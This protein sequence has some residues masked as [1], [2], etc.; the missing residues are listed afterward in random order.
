MKI[1]TIIFI[2]FSTLAMVSCEREKIIELSSATIEIENYDG[3]VI[4]RE[5][6]EKV[7]LNVVAEAPAG[8]HKIEVLVAG[9]VVATEQPENSFTYN[10]EYIY[11]VSATAT[12]G[13]EVTIVFKLE[14]KQG[15][16]VATPVVTIKVAQPFEISDFSI[17]GNA[18]KKISGRINKDITLTND[19][20]WLIDGIVSVDEGANLTIEAGTTV[21]FRTFNNDKYSQLVIMRGGKV[22]ASGSRDKPI[23]FT[24][25][26]VL[27]GTA[28]VSDWGGVYLNGSAP[29]NAANTVLL[30]GF[31]YGGTNVA[32]NSGTLRFVRIEY[33]GKGGLHSLQLNG[34]GSRTTIEYV[35]SFNS[36]NNAFRL[37][38][39]RV[40]LRYIAGIQHG[41]YGIWADEGWQ[42][43]GQFWLFQTNIKATLNP[44]NYWNQARSIEFRNDNSMF[45]KQPRTSFK[46][47]NVTLIGNG[48]GGIEFG[49]RRG[50]RIRRGA[51]GLFYNSIVTEFPSDGVRVEDLPL[52]TLGVNTKIDNVHSFN[53]AINWEQEAKTFF[54]ESGKYN[55]SENPI[56]GITRENF[57]GA[58]PCAFDPVSVG[59]WFVAAPYIGAVHPSSDWTKGGKWFKNY[60][61]SLRQ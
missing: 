50:I 13:E 48:F 57:V 23:V 43:N 51:E 24:S 38:G 25:D 2:M 44:I 55:L 47:S 27:S 39:G 7:F 52:E 59:S 58:L 34:V 22:I 16:I 30:D 42:G 11:Q 14:D 21:Y 12:L 8:V 41:G 33:T 6:S 4:A 3:E 49:T 46:I 61:G 40:S 53:N 56:S 29:T 19:Q 10:Y 28:A 45:N 15:K 60:D 36:Y 1:R 37:R 31:R 9:K 5:P 17:G 20:K 26:K 18:F 54:F 35:Q 32:D